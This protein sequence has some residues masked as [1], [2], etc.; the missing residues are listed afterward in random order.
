MKIRQ[1]FV[2]NSSSSSFVAVL[3]QKKYQEIIDD[4]LDSFV[5]TR[6]EV[7]FVKTQP[8]VKDGN[9]VMVQ[10]GYTEDASYVINDECFD[11]YDDKSCLSDCIDSLE[12]ALR[13]NTKLYYSENR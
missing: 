3:P 7:K 10:C 12:K 13:E 2:S 9:S 8:V 4:L 6:K 11:D 1:Q 5:L